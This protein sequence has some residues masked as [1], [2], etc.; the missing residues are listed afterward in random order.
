MGPKERATMLAG[1]P[2]P[3]PCAS[4]VS[5]HPGSRAT[6]WYLFLPSL[7]FLAFLVSAGP[8]VPR[9]AEATS[10]G[11]VVVLLH[12]ASKAGQ[13]M[14]VTRFA[15][16]HA[17]THAA[18]SKC[19]PSIPNCASN[20]KAHTRACK[21]KRLHTCARTCTHTGQ[22]LRLKPSLRK[23]QRTRSQV[24]AVYYAFVAAISLLNCLRCLVQLVPAAGLWNLLW[25]LTRFG[26]WRCTGCPCAA[27]PPFSTGTWRRA[28]PTRVWRHSGCRKARRP[29]RV[30]DWPAF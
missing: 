5:P 16:V 10:K 25:L 6:F 15:R 7:A 20:A 26:A 11:N 9:G 4:F 24:M 3:P 2:A 29:Q 23:L 21:R 28:Q 19:T 18:N 17:L 30:Q 12:T 1:A 27:A 8:R 22:G 14:L 13:C